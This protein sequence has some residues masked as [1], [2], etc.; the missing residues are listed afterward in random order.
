MY[1][2]KERDLFFILEVM[3][4]H[5]EIEEVILYGSRAMG[6]YKP[7]SDIDLALK[8][9]KVD[10]RILL[11][12]CDSLE[13]V[14]PIPYFFDVLDYKTITNQDLIDHID[15]EGKTIYKRK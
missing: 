11:K 1:G 9:A 10:Q 4:D 3:K 7:G 8:G 6:N 2:L 14:Y 13:E 5:D 15:R 12:V